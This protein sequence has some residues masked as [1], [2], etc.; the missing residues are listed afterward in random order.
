VLVATKLAAYPWRV[1]PGQYVAACR[2]PQSL[3]TMSSRLMLL[4]QRPAPAG[5]PLL[6]CPPWVHCAPVKGPSGRAITMPIEDVSGQGLKLCGVAQVSRR[7]AAHVRAGARGS[8][9]RL[10]KQQL[11]LGQLH[12]SVA[13]YAPPLERALWDGL[14]AM[15]DQARATAGNV[16]VAGCCPPAHAEGLS[17]ASVRPAQAA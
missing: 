17:G 4:M 2:C 11:A 8:L 12:W 15:H 6:T 9:R 3:L 13:K 10:G 16:K 7:G 5:L 14:A 1:T